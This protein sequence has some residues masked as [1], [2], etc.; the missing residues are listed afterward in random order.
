[1][2]TEF[3][4]YLENLFF[5]ASLQ[6]KTRKYPT[7]DF[8]FN[9]MEQS[10]FVMPQREPQMRFSEVKRKFPSGNGLRD[11]E[12]KAYALSCFANHELLAVEIMAFVL[13]TLP[14]Q[15]DDEKKL[16][17]GIYHSLIDEQNHF[18]MYRK[19]MNELGFEFGDFPLTDFF[20]KFS[21][22]IKEHGH[23]L[24]IMPLTFEA[25][26]LDFSAH[27]AKVFEDLGDMETSK[28]LREVYEDE[29]SHVKLGVNY[30][31]RWRQNRTLW[32]YYHS[33][34]PWPLT[35]ARSKGIDFQTAHRVKS[36][37]PDE[38]IRELVVFNDGFRATQRRN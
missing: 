37:F 8:N 31:N 25:A 30:L 7:P 3:K 4:D 27:Y 21:K 16:K 28:I 33:L 18:Q 12:K 17:L 23:Y 2:K 35:P 38:F 24:A 15:T 6:D 32:D 19:R 34:L 10:T 14:H 36:N 11:S 26:N 13:L 29:L 20:W 5:S 9:L 22:D 1:M